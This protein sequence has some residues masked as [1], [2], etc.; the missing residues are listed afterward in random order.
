MQSTHILQL[1]RIVLLFFYSNFCSVVCSVMSDCH[2]HS[3]FSLSTSSLYQTLD[4]LDFERGIWYAAQY[5]DLERVEKLLRQG[6][7]PDIRDAAGYSPL[8][9]AARAGHD[10][11][12]QCLLA[13]GASV[14]AVT[15]A[16][17]A[18]A[19]HRAASAGQDGIVSLLLQRGGKPELRDAD[20]KTAL[21][22][23]VEQNH[24]KTAKI[25]LEANPGLKFIFDSKEKLPLDYAGRNEMVALFAD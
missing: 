12:C 20:G 8:H 18:T 5:D 25:L 11:I 13:A 22:R 24:V 17:Q 23:A 15:R 7:S 3:H 6:V 16:G 2:D 21:H 4:E 10:R 19:L 1:K 9:Y 14:D